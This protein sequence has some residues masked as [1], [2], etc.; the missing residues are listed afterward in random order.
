MP[1]QAIKSGAGAGARLLSGR[2]AVNL[3]IHTLYSSTGQARARL[4]L[5]SSASTRS[6]MQGIVN[7]L[8]SLS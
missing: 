1:N 8:C 5:P 2:K 6:I 4:T 7:L 3:R